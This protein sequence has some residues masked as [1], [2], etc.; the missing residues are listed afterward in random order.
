MGTS[1]GNCPVTSITAPYL[2]CWCAW[3][4]KRNDHFGVTCVR[5]SHYGQPPNEPTGRRCFW[6]YGNRKRRCTAEAVRAV[7]TETT[8]GYYCA[9]HA[10]VALRLLSGADR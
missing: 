6:G 1:R 5:C 4:G 7:D 3:C 2:H 9:E 8:R 10:E